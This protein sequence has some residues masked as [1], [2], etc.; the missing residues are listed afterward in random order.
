MK[1]YLYIVTLLAFLLG[2][3]SSDIQYDKSTKNL[4]QYVIKAVSGDT[5]ANRLLSGLVDSELPNGTEFSNLLIDSMKVE[6]TKKLYSV[7]LQFENPIFNRLAVY[8]SKLNLL[9]I[10][11]SLNGN[12]SVTY[13]K[14]GGLFLKVVEGF[15]SKDMINLKRLSLYK[16][17]T[18]SVR[19]ALRTFISCSK[20][21][22][23]LSQDLVSVSPNM[24][25]TNIAFPE[26]MINTAR[27]DTFFYDSLKK[28]YISSNKIF[29]LLVLDQVKNYTYPTFLPELVEKE[30]NPK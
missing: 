2:C 15:I 14:D 11:K 17:D 7:M 30:N 28:S 8:D 25:I 19:L 23:F 10:D 24:I 9:M 22:I 13:T 29:D 12:I 27:K 21:D 26:R 4:R 1:S 16:L 6:K 18:A 3:S 5:L 20:P